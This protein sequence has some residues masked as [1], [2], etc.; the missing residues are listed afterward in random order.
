MKR[1]LVVLFVVLGCSW[2]QAQDKPSINVQAEVR[3]DYQRE[4]MDG[5]ALDANSGFKGKFLNV[6]AFGKFNEHFSY[7]FRQRLNKAHADQSVFDAT[8]FVNLTYRLNN[9]WSFTGGKQLVNL[10]RMVYNKAS[11]DMYFCTEFWNKFAL[12]Q[13]GLNTT[14]ATAS[15][16]DVFEIQL[17]ESPFDYKN[18]DLYALHLTWYG[19]RDW[20]SSFWS[21]NAMG[22]APGEYIYFLSL[23]SQFKLGSSALKVDFMNRGSDSDFFRLK[24]FSLI[25]ELSFPVQ[26]KLNVYG[27]VS[28]DV[29]KT[30]NTSDFCVLPGTELTR[31]GAGLEYYPLEKGNKNLRFHLYGCY[32]TGQNANPSGTALPGQFLIAGGVKIKVNVFQS[33]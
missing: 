5:N 30:E 20:F 33:K 1:F 27:K 16:K 3:F 22:Y 26:Q 24:D 13:W 9:H 14:Y 4:Y 25:G 11:I 21:L 7:A 18:Q 17:T 23:G 2:A 15:K 31:V 6:I 12:Y 8:D 28:Y 32:A 29:N 19:N 10:G